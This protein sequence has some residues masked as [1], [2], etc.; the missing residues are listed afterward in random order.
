MVYGQVQGCVSLVVKTARD[1]FT[2]TPVMATHFD[3]TTQTHETRPAS[4][5]LS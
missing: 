2:T 1:K 3:A 5:S 4:K